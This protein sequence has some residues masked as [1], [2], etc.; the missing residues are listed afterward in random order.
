MILMFL[1]YLLL[2]VAQTRYRSMHS[3]YP[4]QN[5]KS[6]PEDY[7]RADQ[8]IRET[9]AS[10][11]PSSIV[12]GNAV[13]KNSIIWE[14]SSIQKHSKISYTIIGSNASI[15]RNVEIN[16]SVIKDNVET[17]DY[18]LVYGAKI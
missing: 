13:V 15:G 8:M 12:V 18:L 11:E 10:L 1:H 5:I 14:K 9:S 16:N 4:I 2:Y 3:V 6:L 17:D 7:L